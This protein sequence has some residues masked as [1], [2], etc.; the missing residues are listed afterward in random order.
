MP[1]RGEHP[2]QNER[3]VGPARNPYARRRHLRKHRSGAT[4]DDILEWFDGL[5]RDQVK[6]VIDFAA[7]TPDKPP[8]YVP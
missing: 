6:A 2:R 4:I 7:R 8:A 3:R 5:D 1:R